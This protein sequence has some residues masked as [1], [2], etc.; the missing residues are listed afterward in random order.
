MKKASRIL[1]VGLAAWMLVVSGLVLALTWKTLAHRAVIAM[2]WG[3]IVLWIGGGGLAMWR[4]RD[5]WCRLAARV[6]LPWQVKFVLG[7]TALALIE[8]S[9]AAS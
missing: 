8:A 7:C 3:L 5:F 9:C 2:A 4:W 1:V 6:R